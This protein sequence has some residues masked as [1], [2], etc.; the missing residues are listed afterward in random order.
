MVTVGFAAR[1]NGWRGRSM[2]FAFSLASAIG[3]V[4][5]G[6]GE[7]A[8]PG[9]SSVSGSGGLPGASGNAASNPP[10]GGNGV[11]AASG[12]RTDGPASAYPGDS[13]IGGVSDFGATGG[14][15][16]ATSGAGSGGSDRSAGAGGEVSA[17]TGGGNPGTTAASG[18]AGAGAALGPGGTSAGLAGAEPTVPEGIAGAGFA[19]VESSGGAAGSGG[20][21]GLGGA[22]GS[23][24][25][26]G[27]V[28]LT[29]T[30]T[31]QGLFPEWHNGTDQTIFLPGCASAQVGYWNG[32]AWVNLGGLAQCT[33]EPP[34]R[35]VPAGETFTDP[36]GG[37]PNQPEGTTYRFVGEYGVECI[38]D[39][40]LSEADCAERIELVSN[41][42]VW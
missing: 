3:L 37:P 33:V 24:N 14:R 16:D 11:A 42:V 29:A 13:G 38:S 32:D 6:C 40:R 9:S 26:S 5:V 35:Q 10:G 20:T 39:E 41:E 23:D 19:G 34:A 2:G 27:V 15:S 28:T 22:A 1:N 8:S 7:D 18:A 30:V 17:E 12:G 36:A 31:A 21:G 4:L 25:Q